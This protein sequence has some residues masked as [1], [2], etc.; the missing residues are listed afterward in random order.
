MKK[1]F[2][3]VL[4]V[5]V[6]GT[7]VLLAIFAPPVTKKAEVAAAAFMYTEDERIGKPTSIEL[8]GSFNKEGIFQGALNIGGVEFPHI[9][10][11]PAGGLV[12]YEGKEREVLGSIYYNS[13]HEQYALIISSRETF[14]R[15]TGEKFAEHPLSIVTNAGGLKEAEAQV[16]A[17]RNQALDALEARFKK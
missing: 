16:E 15:L 8:K 14:E 10:F 2:A 3:I 11:F 7:L 1:P 13:E 4:L 5:L 17:I 12:S 9:L 6:L